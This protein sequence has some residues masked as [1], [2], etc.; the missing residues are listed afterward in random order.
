MTDRGSHSASSAEAQGCQMQRFADRVALVT[1]AASGIGE[2]CARRFASEG[3]RVVI[4]DLNEFD[5]RR[6]ASEIGED[7]ALFAR[8]D[9]TDLADWTDLRSTLLQRWGRLDV[10]HAN[11]FLQVSG[12]AHELPESDWDRIQ[13]VDLKAAFLGVKMFVDMLAERRGSIVFTS[14][15]NAFFGRPGRPAYAAAKAGLGG[16]ARQLAV[17]YGPEVRTNV[18]VPGAILTPPWV[19]VSDERRAASAGATAAKRL[20]DP[21]EVAAAVAFLA[22]PEASY[23]TGIELTVDGGW[24]VVKD[25]G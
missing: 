1:G 17:E 8:C 11:A 18:V 20:G 5:G 2:A 13:A 24:S 23:V 25:S 7:R 3:A 21:G 10:L 15:V 14:S 6:V 16:L 4:A 22:S 9:V 19:E 12:A